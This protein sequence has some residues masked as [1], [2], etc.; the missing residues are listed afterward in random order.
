MIERNSS[1]MLPNVYFHYF[2]LWAQWIHWSPVYIQCLFSC[3]FGSET[4]NVHE[5]GRQKKVIALQKLIWHNKNYASSKLKKRTKQFRK[6][7][8]FHHHN[9]SHVEVVW[10]HRTSAEVWCHVFPEERGRVRLRRSRGER[11]RWEE[12]LDRTLPGKR[13]H[14]YRII[15]WN[16]FH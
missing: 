12:D 13:M 5:I 1:F 6:F 11:S 15:N 7:Y 14:I 2:D 9:C 3:F 8:R 16:I 10:R 4:T